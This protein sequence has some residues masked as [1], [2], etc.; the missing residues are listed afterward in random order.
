MAGAGP[1]SR[2]RCTAA[3]W[4]CDP[5]RL[6]MAGA[7]SPWPTVPSMSLLLRSSPAWNGRCW[8]TTVRSICLRRGFV[9][10]LTG[11]EWPVLAVALARGLR[12]LMVA[13][14]TGLEWPVL[15][16]NNR[17]TA[18]LDRLLRSSPAW[19][20]RCWLAGSGVQRGEYV[21]VAILTGLE[22]PVL[23]ARRPAAASGDQV[24]ILTGL[25]Q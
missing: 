22:W 23:A 20:G 13:I 16:E 8:P 3:R 7:G 17:L 25:D 5:H 6:G 11:L 21:R 15:A 24:A 9:A 19:N 4:G 10:I 18:E 2:S 1:R 12:P 14:L